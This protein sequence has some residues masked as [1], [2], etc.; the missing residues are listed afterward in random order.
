MTKTDIYEYVPYYVFNDAHLWS[1]KNN[2]GDESFLSY[3]RSRSFWEEFDPEFA[4]S[5]HNHL[6]DLAL[7]GLSWSDL[8]YAKGVSLAMDINPATYDPRDHFDN[9]YIEE[10][11]QRLYENLM[12][13][14]LDGLARACHTI[15]D[16]YAHSSYA[17]FAR[18]DGAGHL[19]LF[20]GVTTD[21]RFAAVP[22][23]GKPDFDLH[24]TARFTVNK[25]MCTLTTED[26]IAYCNGRKL[27]SGRFAQPRDPY[28]GT[29]EK[30]FISIPYELRNRADFKDRTCLPH[31]NEIAVDSDLDSGGNIPAGHGLYGDSEVYSSQF[32][33]RLKAATDHMRQFY[34]VWNS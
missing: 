34:G 12:K 22:D 31:H 5:V 27:I 19:L 6:F 26:A 33:L 8:L 20:D 14:T 9:G 11:W 18:K 23:Y 29:L 32:K 3:L 16:F 13:K 4:A 24:D 1:L 2:T 25:G 7:D 28:Q 30:L 21:D 15:A 17:H 10:S